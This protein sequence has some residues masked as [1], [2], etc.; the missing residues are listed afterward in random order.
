MAA[1]MTRLRVWQA[2]RAAPATAFTTTPE[3]RTIGHFARGRQLIAGN[4]LFAGQLFEA[5]GAAIWDL[6]AGDPHFIEQVQGCAWLDDLAAVG[7]ERA[8]AQA[9]DWVYGWIERYGAGHGAGWAPDITGR[10]LIRW[11]NHAIFIMRGRPKE[12]VDAFFASLSTQTR[13]LVRRWKSAPDGLPR[14]EA[15]TGVIYSGLALEGLDHLVGPA[16][17]AMAADCRDTIAPT[18]AIPSR[19]P[20]ALLQVLTL[21]NWAVAAMQDAEREV[22]PEY[23]EARRAVVPTQRALRHSDGSLARFHGGGRG[24]DGWLDSALAASG[25]S[26]GQ[27][28]GLAMGFARMTAGRTTLIADATP[29]PTGPTSAEAHASTLAFE[30]T[31]GRRPIVVNCGS[32]ARFGAEWRRAGRATPSHSTLGLEGYSSSRLAPAATAGARRV[33]WLADVP[34]NVPIEISRTDGGMKLEIAHDGW[35][36]THG[37]THARS[38]EL[39]TDGR[40]LVGEEL[41]TTLNAADEA[42]FDGALDS[43]NL[44]GIAF[45]IRFHLHP[46]VD[47]EIDMGGAAVSVALKSGEVWVF[48]H[49]GAQEMR[50]DSSVYLETGRL[51]PRGSKQVVLT[52]RAM[53]YATRIRWSLAKAQE[54]PIAVRDYASDGRN[55][56]FTPDG[57]E[58]Q[59]DDAS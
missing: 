46:D 32:G 58:I 4:Y 14:Y 36:A 12:D 2:G 23:D 25:V 34:K 22:P 1:Y 52:G 33:D 42:Q 7:D 43:T 56:G 50:L 5:P 47:A 37:L 54:T 16:I 53:S 15:L 8:R 29:P 40:A 57:R 11:I 59:D 6:G 20:E 3:P 41:L 31:S 44:Q 49:S 51:R 35:R 26:A 18:G 10:R 39:A 13:Y 38:I 28:I 45:S 21:L 55:I 30:L 19:N 24:L 27:P 17:A 9:Q 48:R